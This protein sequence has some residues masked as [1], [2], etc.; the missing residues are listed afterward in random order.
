MIFNF[1]LLTQ[2]TIFYFLFSSSLR[3]RTRS[4]ALPLSLYLRFDGIAIEIERWRI[5]W[6]QCFGCCAMLF[7]T[8]R[9]LI[10]QF[11]YCMDGWW[12]SSL[13]ANSKGLLIKHDFHIH[14]KTFSR[15][16][17][18]RVTNGIQIFTQLKH[19]MENNARIKDTWFFYA[20]FLFRFSSS[21]HCFFFLLVCF[22]LLDFG[23][24]VQSLC[25]CEYRA[26]FNS[27]GI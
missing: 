21:H 6:N 16:P 23:A 10:G 22:F 18:V 13:F 25:L 2:H 1:P 9:W 20:L 11:S 4:L 27:H 24:A 19:K 3:Y 7:D 5:V 12:L 8:R 26:A 15:F 17:L 14:Q